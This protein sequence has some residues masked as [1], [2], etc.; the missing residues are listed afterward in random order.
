MGTKVLIFLAIFII[1]VVG[2]GSRYENKRA[3]EKESL[4]N[5]IRLLEGKINSLEAG[6]GHE[7]VV[8]PEDTSKDIVNSIPDEIETPTIKKVPVYLI[9]DGQTLNCLEIGEQALIEASKRLLEIDK[10]VTECENSIRSQITSCVNT[11]NSKKD[12]ESA[13]C[14]IDKPN[15]ADCYINAL[16]SSSF[17]LD[18]CKSIANDCDRDEGSTYDSINNLIIKYCD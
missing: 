8:E 18:N 7:E 12:T 5:S 9:H 10:A 16:T 15:L 3:K 11:C 2:V 4:E 1:A 14:P 13:S 6:E 17:C